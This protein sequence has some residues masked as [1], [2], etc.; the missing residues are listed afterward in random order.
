[1]TT[2]TFPAS[3]LHKGLVVRYADVYGENTPTIEWLE[4]LREEYPDAE[5]TWYTGVDSVVPRSEF[6]GECEIEHYWVRGQEL[7]SDWPF[8]II[9][10]PGY[11]DPR[12]LNLPKQFK[13][14]TNARLPDTASSEARRRIADGISITDLVMPEVEQYIHLHGLYR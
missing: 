9:P 8:L 4:R 13:I 5:I 6:G 2:L 7:M 11:E 10:R 1:M 3:W 14:M 12:N